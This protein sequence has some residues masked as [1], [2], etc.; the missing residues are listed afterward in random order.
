M[1]QRDS[2]RLR[3]EG[4]DHGISYTEF[5]YMILQ[6]YDY[7][8]LATTR[9]VRLQ[10]GG[11]DQWGN[12]VAGIDLTRRLHKTEVFG[13]TAPLLTK[14]DGGKFGKTESGAV[15][16]TRKYTSPYA[17]YQFWINAGDDDVETFLRVFS[18]RPLAEIEALL[19]EHRENAAARRAQKSLA[20]EMTRLL[21]GDE[22]LREAELASEALFSGDVRSLS[23]PLLLEVFA[24]M[25]RGVVDDALVEAGLPIV[26]ALVGSEAVKSK[27]EA[28]QFLESGAITLIGEKVD[29]SYILRVEDFLF[30]RVA[31]VRRGKKNWHVVGLRSRFS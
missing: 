7:A 28:R 12:I 27:R 21:H 25:P 5:S 22:G 2:V 11:S 1:I 8:H 16:L 10:I 29:V 15:W 9:G 20:E 4:R 31:L 3:L 19:A 24:A 30:G 18:F 17:F 13:L 23:E 14:A 6:A 26:D